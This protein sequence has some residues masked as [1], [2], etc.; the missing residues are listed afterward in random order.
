MAWGIELDEAGLAH[1]LRATLERLAAELEAEPEDPERLLRL[2]R[3]V[4]LA[5]SLPFHVPLAGVQNA[6]WR[7]QEAELPGRRA[8]AEAGDEAARAWA[9]GF[10]ALGESLEMRVE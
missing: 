8:A 1:T 6:Y 9:E 5:R 10:R 2:H 3:R 7:L 4:E